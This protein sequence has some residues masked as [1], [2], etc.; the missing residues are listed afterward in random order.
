MGVHIDAYH[1]YKKISNKSPDF[2]LF[3]FFMFIDLVDNCTKKRVVQLLFFFEY[4]IWCISF[5]AQLVWYRENMELILFQ[6]YSVVQ[7]KQNM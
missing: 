2:F 3:F 5:Y 1:K 6:F 4:H 7:I